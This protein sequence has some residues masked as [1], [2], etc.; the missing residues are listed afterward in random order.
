MTFRGGSKTYIE[1]LERTLPQTQRIHRSTPVRSLVRETAGTISLRTASKQVEMFDHV[2][3]ATG[4]R[5]SVGILGKSA[6]AREKNVLKKFDTTQNLCVLHSD[7]SV[8]DL[9]ETNF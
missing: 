2:V 8:S 1:A 6:T 7:I 9:S 4:A 5:E 3:L